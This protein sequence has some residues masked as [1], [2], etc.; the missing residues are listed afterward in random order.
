MM[1]SSKNRYNTEE[2]VQ[3]ILEPGSESELSELSSDDECPDEE[4][5]MLHEPQALDEG[6]DDGK[7]DANDADETPDT[8]T[9]LKWRKKELAVVD[10]MFSGTE[11]TCPDNVN[12]LHP[13]M[14][15]KV[16]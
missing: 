16:F 14:Y 10:V 3:Y 11:L 7:S 1:E 6:A 15:F 5:S 12:E 2:A 4:V 9:L 13:F 8:E